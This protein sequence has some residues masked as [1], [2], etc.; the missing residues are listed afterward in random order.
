MLATSKRDWLWR[1]RDIVDFD[2]FSRQ[3]PTG[4]LTVPGVVSCSR[5]CAQIA[6]VATAKIPKSRDNRLPSLRWHHTRTGLR[7]R[8][9]T[10]LELRVRS[11]AFKKHSKTASRGRGLTDSDETQQSESLLGATFWSTFS[12]GITYK[13]LKN[14]RFSTILL[15]SAPAPSP[16]RSPDQKGEFNFIV[17]FFVRR[18]YCHFLT[19]FLSVT[20]IYFCPYLSILS[21][22]SSTF[23]CPY[24]HLFVCPH[25]SIFVNTFFCPC[26]HRFVSNFR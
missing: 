26:C 5:L 10:V 21:I 12:S 23:F 13:I 8:N 25:L 1:V 4:Q 14:R 15:A 16:L 3:T 18:F 7:T 22:L 17:N 19:T 9:P 11:R 24:C 20:G 6:S 2:G